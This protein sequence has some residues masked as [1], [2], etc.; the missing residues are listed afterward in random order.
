MLDHTTSNCDGSIYLLYPSET[1]SF[2]DVDGPHQV[3]RR[4]AIDSAKAEAKVRYLH[5]GIPIPRTDG[6]V[7]MTGFWDV[8]VFPL[9]L[10]RLV[11]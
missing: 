1:G 8:V 10:L 11:H 5:K 2:G 4:N 7:T 6:C 9:P 3:S